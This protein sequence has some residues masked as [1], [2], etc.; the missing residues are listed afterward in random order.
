M[1][2]RCRVCDKKPPWFNNLVLEVTHS[3]WVEVSKINYFLQDQIPDIRVD[4]SGNLVVQKISESILVKW[5]Q[6]VNWF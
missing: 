2:Q 6:I 4:V 5:Y 1:P 3:N